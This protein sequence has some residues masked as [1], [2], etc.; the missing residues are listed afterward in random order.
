MSDKLE[1][2]L[3]E[4]FFRPVLKTVLTPVRHGRVMEM[5]ARH[6]LEVKYTEHEAIIKLF[7]G[8]NPF[9][10]QE[11]LEA[12]DGR[13]CLEVVECH[14]DLDK[15]A[16]SAVCTSNGDRLT[17]Y[18]RNTNGEY[19]FQKWVH[20]RFSF[21]LKMLGP[22]CVVALATT[23]SGFCVE[24]RAEFDPGA[25][26][27]KVNKTTISVTPRL[28]P[29]LYQARLRAKETPRLEPF[30]TNEQRHRHGRPLFDDEPV[31]DDRLLPHRPP[32]DD[33]PPYPMIEPERSLRRGR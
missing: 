14:W 28:R 21:P 6:H 19:G 29:V 3:P 26:E 9:P 5:E 17:A 7:E 20:A 10:V 16:G 4:W 32:D 31:V 1:L 15:P 30:C 8:V 23:T 25:N 12:I 22:N 2:T 13:L 27:I 11:V 33:D 24:V 18:W